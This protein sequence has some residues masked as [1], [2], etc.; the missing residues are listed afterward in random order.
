M[1]G[2][3][4][5]CAVATVGRIVPGEMA[6]F[7]QASNSVAAEEGDPF[8]LTHCEEGEAVFGGGGV[9]SAIPG[10]KK[11]EGLFGQF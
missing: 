7:D 2:V 8:V 1:F 9:L 5:P 10:L 4:A 11:C 3:D 6:V